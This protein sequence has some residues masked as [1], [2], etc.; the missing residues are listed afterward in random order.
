VAVTALKHSVV[1]LLG[2]ALIL[3]TLFFEAVVPTAVSFLEDDIYLPHETK[4]P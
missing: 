3:S 1:L 2:G 4:R